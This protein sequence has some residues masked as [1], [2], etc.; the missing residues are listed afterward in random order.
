M[1]IQILEGVP[2][3]GGGRH[4]ACGLGESF[5]GIIAKQGL[6]LTVGTGHR[7]QVLGKTIGRQ[8]CPRIAGRWG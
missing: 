2:G 8:G 7:I 1:L 5:A 6:G 4:Q 3:G